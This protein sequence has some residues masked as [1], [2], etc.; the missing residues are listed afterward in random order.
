MQILLKKLFDECFGYDRVL[1]INRAL[2]Y[3][4]YWQSFDVE[5]AI[6]RVVLF[7][8]TCELIFTFSVFIFTYY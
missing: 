6:G 2:V 4:I 5:P 7:K 3:T 1:L 8:Q